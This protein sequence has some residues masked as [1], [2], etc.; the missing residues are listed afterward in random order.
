MKL[1]FELKPEIG[2]ALMARARAARIFEI[3]AARTD[4]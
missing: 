4:L 1:E 2:E 3:L